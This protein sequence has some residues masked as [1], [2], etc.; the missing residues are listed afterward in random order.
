MII[1]A[2]DKKLLSAN[3]KLPEEMVK[4]LMDG[5]NTVVFQHTDY[6][7]NHDLVVDD[8]MLDANKTKKF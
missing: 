1:M 4:S 7:Y 6:D 8:A 2:N 5:W 3:I